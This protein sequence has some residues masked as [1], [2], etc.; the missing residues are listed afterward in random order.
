MSGDMDTF[1]ALVA[2][3]ATGRSLSVDEACTAFDIMMSGDA[4]PSQMG[5]FLMAL[6]VRGETVDEITGGAMTMRAKALSVTCERLTTLLKTRS[7]G[8]SG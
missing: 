4:T 7:I 2:Q 1:K 5:A 3:V 6:R 8:G